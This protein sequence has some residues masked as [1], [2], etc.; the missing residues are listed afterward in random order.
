[1]TDP[2][3]LLGNLHHQ[4]RI[5]CRFGDGIGLAQFGRGLSS[6]ISLNG[7]FCFQ[8][9]DRSFQKL[10]VHRSSPSA[11]AVWNMPILGET[12]V[13]CQAWIE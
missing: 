10:I 3:E 2:L 6:S 9:Q 4:V 7:G 13:Q 8:K 1:L 5:V 11:M 12:S